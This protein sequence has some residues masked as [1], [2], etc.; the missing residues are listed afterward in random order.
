M[1][2]GGG[3]EEIAGAR[4]SGEYWDRVAAGEFADDVRYW[5]GV[6]PVRRWVNR[7]MT[8]DPD[9]L[10]IQKF[11]EGL[12]ERWPL[13]RALSIGCGAGDLERGAVGL[14][15]VAS[16]E[17]SDVGEG[18]IRVAREAAAREGLAERIHYTVA[19]AAGH[20]EQ[21]LAA[22][23]RFDVIFFH[24]V[25]HHLAD[26][27]VVLERTGRLLRESPPGLVY[28]D[29]YM[30]PSRNRWT[31]EHLAWA[32]GLFARVPARFRRTPQVLPPIAMEDPTEMIRSDEIERVVR[33]RL[34]IVDWMPYYGNVLNPLVCSIRGSALEEP[35]VAR[36]LD[37]A[38][39]LED[40]LI[41]RGLLEPFYAACIARVKAV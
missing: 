35:E 17:G 31:P 40:W 22:R 41:A 36:V 23:E 30:G 14:G 25:L 15:A 10:Y 21:L 3:S 27:E 2:E 9:K 29:E 13:P 4:R 33:E 16:I 12:R 11:L 28:I 39:A 5:L 32:S 1:V 19:D 20:L 37:D 8:G 34:E 7:R 38:M 24:G 18:S 26:L 6:L